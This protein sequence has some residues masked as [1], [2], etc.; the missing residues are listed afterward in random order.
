M[1]Q[2]ST[3]AVSAIMAQETDEAFLPLL[4]ISHADLAEPIRLVANIENISSRGETYIGLPFEIEFPQE[5][6]EQIGAA[7]L[8]VDNVD[9]MIVQTLRT[10][11]TP[12][13]VTVEVVLA[14]QPDTV[15]MALTNLTLRDAAYDALAVTG[16]LRPEDVTE[17]PI[18]ETITPTRFPGLF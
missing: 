8:R 12:P 1:R 11:Q 4:T 5:D 18:G 2:L 9:R 6:G 10:I 16:Y 7:R 14:S 17:E 3:A 13:T 15:E